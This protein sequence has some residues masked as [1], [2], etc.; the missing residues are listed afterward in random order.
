MTA[1]VERPLRVGLNLLYLIRRRW[2]GR[3]AEELLP[4][5]LELEPKT[6]LV[7]FTT[8]RIDSGLL[9]EPWAE[10]VEWVRYDVAPGSPAPLVAQLARIPREVARSASTWSTARA[11][12]GCP[13]PSVPPTS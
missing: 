7:A 4:A 10:H 8:T 6:R 12:S 11:T 5:I 13:R 3:Y 9:A 1:D 2:R